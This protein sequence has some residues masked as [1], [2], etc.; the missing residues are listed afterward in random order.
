MPSKNGSEYISND[1]MEVGLETRRLDMT[2]ASQ[3][4]QP[5]LDRPRF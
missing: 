5:G 1:T 4:E 2:L 3:T